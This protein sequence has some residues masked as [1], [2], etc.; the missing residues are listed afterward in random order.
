MLNPESPF[1]LRLRP[2]PDLIAWCLRFALSCNRRHVNHSA[3]VLRDLNL[4]SRSLYAELAHEAE[5]AFSLVERGILMVYRTAQ[6]EQEEVLLA[7]KAA[8][9][10]L[11]VNVLD[12]AGIRELNPSV[13]PDRPRRRPFFERRACLAARARRGWLRRQ[14]EEMG[15]RR[16]NTEVTGFQSNC[17]R[18]TGI[19]MKEGSLAIDG[20]L[21]IAGGA[22]SAGLVRKLGARIHLQPGKGYSMTLEQPRALP[23]IPM[24]LTEAKVAV[25]PMDG[26]LRF[27][28][29][30]EIGGFDRGVNRSRLRGIVNS[31]PHYLPDFRPDDFSRESVWNGLR[32]CSSDGL[33]YLG[34]IPGWK[35]ASLATGHGM[36]GLS[37][38]PITGKL[39][40]ELLCDDS[41]SMSLKPFRI[42]R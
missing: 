1:A 8:D 12:S 24:L 35:N 13:S 10:G 34:R 40:S 9:L 27:A 16:L 4:R 19:K 25:T 17:S 5:N 36:M 37:L 20:E 11:D 21:V 18:V 2:S 33:P 38:A 31:I 3:P 15:G 26:S 23:E 28:G 14:F 41:S 39:I 30:M 32:P 29:T 6:A 22:W 42:G 7:K